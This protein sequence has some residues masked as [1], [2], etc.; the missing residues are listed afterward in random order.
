MKRVKI[1]HAPRGKERGKRLLSLSLSF[2]LAHLESTEAR[3]SHPDRP[4]YRQLIDGGEGR[5]E[6]RGQRGG[7]GEEEEAKAYGFTKDRAVRGAVTR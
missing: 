1:S 7:E 4:Y 5:G 3:V 2:R 6:T